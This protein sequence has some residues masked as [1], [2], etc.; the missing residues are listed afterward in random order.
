MAQ[1]P[2][3]SCAVVIG[4][5]M[6]GGSLGSA[7]RQRGVAGEV[8]GV[9]RNRDALERGVALG[10]LDRGTTELSEVVSEADLIVLA[11]PVTTIPSLMEI[12][13]PLVESHVL[14]TDLGSTKQRIVEEGERL[15]GGRFVGGHPMAG[16]PQGGVEA[17][18]P[19]LFAGAAWAIVGSHRPDPEQASS[20]ALLTEMV[21]A[22][23]AR[24][25]YL[26]SEEHDRLVALVSHLPHL[27]SFAFAD[28]VAGSADPLAARQMAGGSFRD[29]MRVSEADR[30][31]WDAIFQENRTVL[32]QALD[33]Y[34]AS[35]ALLRAR[36]TDS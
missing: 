31:F 36:I 7:L 17:A 20:V 11:T 14:I 25:I 34:E 6:M 21:R 13:K 22:L 27:L 18:L 29:L 33:A 10:V 19:D 15:F 4:V 8:V 28:A 2:L 1:T 30:G 35:L 23:G 26:G 24:P 3:F 16:S 5:G 32:I 12:L 9:D